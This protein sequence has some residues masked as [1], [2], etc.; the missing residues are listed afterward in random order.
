[1]T[2]G[3]NPPGLAFDSDR[4]HRNQLDAA[5]GLPVNLPMRF[6]LATQLTIL[7]VATWSVLAGALM[8]L[9]D[10]EFD[11]VGFLQLLLAMLLLGTPA[12][13][14]AMSEHTARSRFLWLR[15]PGS[16][17]D[18]W[19]V[20]ESFA[21]WRQADRVICMTVVC[22]LIGLMRLPAGEVAIYVGAAI[23]ATF[24]IAYL[25]MA[26]TIRNWPMLVS[27]PRSVV[28]AVAVPLTLITRADVAP[29]ALA[30]PASIVATI[31]LR[32]LARDGF[33]SMDWARASVSKNPRRGVVT[34]LFAG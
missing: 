25:E 32:Q 12:Q 13:A 7:A 15:Q 34:A 19:R 30:I 14:I 27:V 5:W 22:S 26:G 17:A 21:F 1:M 24:F 33:Q 20:L 18:H 28:V 8:V 31:V 10:R 11:V 9:A 4:R 2:T 6:L 16:R 29:Y 23:A 3:M